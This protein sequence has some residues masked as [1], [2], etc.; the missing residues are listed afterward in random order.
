M[1]PKE[2]L[3]M[4]RGAAELYVTKGKKVFHFNMQKDKPDDGTLLGVLIGPSGNLRAPTFKV[5]K[6]MV[7]G[8]DEE[9]YAKLLK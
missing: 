9:T 5:G 3:A 6:T 2:A 8:F 7:V 1:T 4:A